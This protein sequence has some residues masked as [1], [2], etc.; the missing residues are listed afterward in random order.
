MRLVLRSS[1]GKEKPQ[2]QNAFAAALFLEVPRTRLQQIIQRD[3]TKKLS[4]ARFN[5]RKP[6]HSFLC[7]TVHH[8]PQGLIRESFNR[9]RA[10]LFMTSSVRTGSRPPRNVYLARVTNASFPFLSWN[11]SSCSS[12]RPEYARLRAGRR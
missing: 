12:G 6:G 8:G 10:Q 9:L 5:D 7:H 4:R 2:I 11:K 1:A 3:E